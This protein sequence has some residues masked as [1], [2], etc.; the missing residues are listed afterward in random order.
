MKLINKSFEIVRNNWRTYKKLNLIFYGLIILGMLIARFVPASLNPVADS[1]NDTMLASLIG[2]FRE[3]SFFSAFLVIFIVNLTL[4]SFAEI[5]IPSLIIPFSGFLVGVFRM[6]LWGIIFSPF[7]RELSFS[8]TSI[9][10]GFLFVLVMLLEGQG[11]ILTLLGT[12]IHGRDSLFPDRIGLKN[13]KEGYLVGLKKIIYLY[14]LIAI[15]L[16]LAALQE[17]VNISVF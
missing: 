3:M 5:I 4:G 16:L 12:Y 14:P 1:S 11:Y 17:A 6:F 7:T 15:V 8:P 2:R 9:L 13:K 10:A